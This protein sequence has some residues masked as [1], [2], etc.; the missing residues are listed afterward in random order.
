MGGGDPLLRKWWSPGTAAQSCCCPIPGGAW[1]CVG[2][3]LAT[4]A[5]ER[6]ST[7][8]RSSWNK[9][10]S[11]YRLSVF[12][13]ER[14]QAE[15]TFIYVSCHLFF[16]IGLL[17][18]YQWCTLLL[19]VLNNGMVR[20]MQEKGV[21]GDFIPKTLT[22]TVLQSHRLQMP[23]VINRGRHFTLGNEIQHSVFT[24]KKC[25]IIITVF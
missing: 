21:A 9:E 11:L 7:H 23:L 22:C 15:R 20:A 16:Q 4:W 5:G 2:W 14:Q 24:W 25:C 19:I 13:W 1:G 12:I 6:P 3:A 17:V 10:T 18:E 8:N